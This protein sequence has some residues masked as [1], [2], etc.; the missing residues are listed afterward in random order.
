MRKHMAS[1]L[2]ARALLFCVLALCACDRAAELEYRVLRTLP[3]DSGAYTQG[4]VLHEG[5]LW[6]STGRYGESSVRK[7]RIDTG[8][9]V[10]IHRLP[11]QYFGEG[12]AVVDS[13]L[14]Q[15]TWK[16]GVAFV[17]ELDSLSP[18]DTLAYEGEG[19]GLCYDGQALYMTNGSSTLFRRDARTFEVLDSLEITRDGFPIWNLNELECVGEDVYANVFLRDEILQIDKATGRVRGVLDAWT[20]VVGSRRPAETDAVLNGIAYDPSARTFF[21]TGKLWPALFE[22]EID[23]VGGRR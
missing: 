21:V 2:R 7:V 20:L 19:W 9:I 14:V 17:Y 8:E 11:E 3:H 18:R 5:W 23:G 15:L 13:Q 16:E 10:Q 4:L 6:E 12:L 22:L 1:S